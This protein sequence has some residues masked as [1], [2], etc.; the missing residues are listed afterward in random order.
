MILDL[1]SV[2]YLHDDPFRF[3]VLAPLLNDLDDKAVPHRELLLNW[4]QI[5]PNKELVAFDLEI[6]LRNALNSGSIVFTFQII[7]NISKLLHTLRDYN[8]LFHIFQTFIRKD[9]LN[10]QLPNKSF[11]S[12]YL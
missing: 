6:I 7:D 8:S 12:K 11:M 5:R 3:E 2:K 9:F 4:I 10:I 1:L